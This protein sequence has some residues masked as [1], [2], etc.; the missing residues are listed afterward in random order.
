MRQSNELEFHSMSSLQLGVAIALATVT[1][2]AVPDL[3]AEQAPPPSSSTTVADCLPEFNPS[4]P[5][6]FTVLGA[7]F[8]VGAFGLCKRIAPEGPLVEIRL[9][10]AKQSRIDRVLYGEFQGDLLLIYEISDGES[11]WGTVVRL[12]P[13]SLAMKWR[14]NLPSFNVSVGTIEGSRL[15]QAG[16]GFVAAIDLTR[17]TFVWKRSGLYE[18]LTQSFH[19]FQ[20]PEVAMREVI[21]REKPIGNATNSPRT[22]RV[23]KNTG[24]ITVR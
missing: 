1:F 15:Y 23:Q 14:L 2:S 24:R 22:I 19:A 3:V 16:M 18:Q 10:L 12:V 4:D 9:P 6:R 8:E 13:R 5:C 20:R 11:G 7:N 17:G 21:F